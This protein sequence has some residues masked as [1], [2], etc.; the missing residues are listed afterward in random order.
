M[1]DHPFSSKEIYHLGRTLRKCIKIAGYLMVL[2]DP[3]P[4]FQQVEKYG[5]GTGV[6]RKGWL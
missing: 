3:A 1:M 4:C 5:K 2:S 6:S